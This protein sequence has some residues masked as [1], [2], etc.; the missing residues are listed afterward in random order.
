M[1]QQQ[2]NN[3]DTGSLGWWFL[4]FFIPFVG[5][6]LFIVYL[7]SKPKTAKMAGWGALSSCVIVPVVLFV[8]LFAG[9]YLRQKYDEK[10]S[11]NT[12]ISSTITSTN[13]KINS[14]S[15]KNY[16]GVDTTD[17]S[18]AQVVDWITYVLDNWENKNGLDWSYKITKN[19]GMHDPSSIYY[20]I[21]FNK[22]NKELAIRINPNGVME[23]GTN[24]ANTAP[25]YEVLSRSFKDLNDI[26]NLTLDYVRSN[27]YA[28]TNANISDDASNYNSLNIKQKISLMAL[29]NLSK[30]GF[31]FQNIVS[32]TYNINELR[33]GTQEVIIRNYGLNA[34]TETFAYKVDKTSIRLATA[35][36]KVFTKN[37]LFKVYENNKSQYEE[38]ATKVK[39]D[40][41]LK[42]SQNN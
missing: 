16:D 24:Q 23:F 8:S 30:T 10:H 5:V 19:D 3:Q 26:D 20:R 41:S 22:D 4:G 2:N 28:N 32:I 18:E 31:N 42:F 29:L 25:T 7:G 13:E 1:E 37:D 40:P 9:T 12:T 6:I 39:H 35:G 34:H 11:V 36:D 14:S 21:Q 38:L 33:D 15:E 17:L 27:P